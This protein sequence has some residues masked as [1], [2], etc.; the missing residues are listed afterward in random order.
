[1]DLVEPPYSAILSLKKKKFVM[2]AL[3]RWGWAWPNLTRWRRS[4]RLSRPRQNSLSS[5]LSHLG[6]FLPMAVSTSRLCRPMHCRVDS[7]NSYVGNIISLVDVLPHQENI[8]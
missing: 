6:L 4:S 2:E 8:G 1:M 5:L 7:V 3:M